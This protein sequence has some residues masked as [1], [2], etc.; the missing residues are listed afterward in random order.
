[1]VGGAVLGY[2]S[3]E[4]TGRRFVLARPEPE[5]KVGRGLRTVTRTGPG[6]TAPDV[7]RHAPA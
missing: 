7:C 6:T 3:G 4:Q 2:R 5:D 1:M